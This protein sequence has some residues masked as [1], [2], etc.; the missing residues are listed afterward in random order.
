M[1][2]NT[3]LSRVA[4]EF[5]SDAWRS[6]AVRSFIS[7]LQLQPDELSFQGLNRLL[8]LSQSMVESKG[9]ESRAISKGQIIPSRRS[10]YL[11]TPVAQP[12]SRAYQQTCD[13]PLSIHPISKEFR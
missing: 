6:L 9:F 1:R 4:F 3:K 2:K 13:F 8:G 11:V 10:S 5:E 7:R 12:A